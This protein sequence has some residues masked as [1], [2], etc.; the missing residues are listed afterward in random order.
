MVGRR[1]TERGRAGAAVGR[2]H[3]PR[4]RWVSGWLGE[5]SWKRRP[6]ARLCLL[7]TLSGMTR[8]L[9]LDSRASLDDTEGP[10]TSG[11]G[12]YAGDVASSERACP[13]ARA[14]RS[15]WPWSE[16]WKSLRGASSWIFS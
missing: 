12:V 10:M 8:E 2:P 9:R 6:G 5:D 3:C 13:R 7:K 4:G 1:A 11:K 15:A 14:V 16:R